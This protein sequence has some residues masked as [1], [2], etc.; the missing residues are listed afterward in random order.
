MGGSCHP[1]PPLCG[2]A[3]LALTA[4]CLLPGEWNS[5][6]HRPSKCQ[7]NCSDA[8]PAL[9]G[10]D[11]ARTGCCTLLSSFLSLPTTYLAWKNHGYNLVLYIIFHFCSTPSNWIN[12]VTT[13]PGTS[14]CLLGIY[15]SLRNILQR[16]VMV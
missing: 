15:I 7:I 13:D 3:F 2:A 8:A 9:V 6:A 5:P 1:L 10:P 12:S 14:H 11:Q 16:M 4:L